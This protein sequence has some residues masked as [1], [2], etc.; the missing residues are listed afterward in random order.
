MIFFIVVFIYYGY[1]YSFNQDPNEIISELVMDAKAISASLI[2]QGSP[3]D[4]NLTNVQ[5]IGLT[6]GNQ[7][8]MQNK[9]DMIGNF[10][11]NN[12]SSILRTR[13]DYFIQLIELNGSIINISGKEGVGLAPYN[14]DNVIAITRIVVYDSRLISMVVKVWQ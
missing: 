12:L 14:E 9:I 8:I 6:D 2:T 5:I 13:Y 7:R 3:N 10:S 1:A 4:W 11:Y